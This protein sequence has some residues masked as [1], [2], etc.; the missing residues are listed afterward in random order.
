MNFKPLSYSICIV[1]CLSS[2]IATKNKNYSFNN[3]Y[4]P[5][6]VKDDIVL[7]YQIFQAN[8]PSLYWYT[9]KDSIEYYFNQTL[10]SITD[11]LTEIEAKNK[12]AT[13][14]AK[15]KCGH[16]SVR[17]SKQF[18]KLADKYKYPQFPLSIKTWKDS[19][20]VLGYYN[21]EDSMLK[22]G[23]IITAINGKSLSQITAHIFP[24]ISTDGE[25]INY[26][27][28]TLSGNFPAWYR[29]T[30][31]ID[32]TY[33]I[34]Y[35]DTAHLLKTITIKALYPPQKDT[36]RKID[37]IVKTIAI[38]AK[39]PTRKEKL[40]AIRSLKIDSSINTGYMRLTTFSKGNLRSFF[41]DC[42]DE[43]EEKQVKNLVIDLRENGGGSVGATI[44][45]LQYLKDTNFKIADTCMA[46]N[47]KLTYKKHIKGW[48]GYWFLTHLSSSKSDDGLYHNHRF[49]THY[50]KPFKRKHFNGNIYIIQGGYTFSAATILSSFLQHQK[51]VTI[52]G[53]ETGGG[54]YG[55]SA[56][57]I[58]NIILPNTKLQ[59]RLPLYR[60][61]MNKERP[62]GRGI[63]PD[64][65]IQPNSTA[66]QQGI[67][68][69][70]ATLRK[71]IEEKT[72]LQSQ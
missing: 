46:I 8:H 16:T 2:C 42:F 31:S 49:E 62:K 32:S 72:K 14:V 63:I 57:L 40:L 34:S 60:Y 27:Y 6:K 4:A 9:P 20:V 35:I 7:L 69:K 15:I 58:P 23:T 21:K 11:S 59:V 36:T 5:Q 37:S 17:Y 64:I 12:I 50:F 41:A 38:P 54:Y 22:R 53:E 28:Q 56:M 65:E 25:D 68:I 13:V 18:L 48:L 26:K 3:K 43:L 66:I 51:N 52:V 44:N 70:L 61:V 10:A 55:N 71:I 19:M 39:K 24:L 45:L 47:R 67:D 30:F 29:T 1:I 33:K